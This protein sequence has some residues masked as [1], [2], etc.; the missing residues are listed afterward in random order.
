MKQNKKRYPISLII[1]SM[2]LFS[3]INGWGEFK[4]PASHSSQMSQLKPRLAVQ[5]GHSLQ[6]YHTAFSADGKYLVTSG[7]GRSLRLW[8]VRS[9]REIRDFQM[10]TTLIA[11]LSFVGKS[12]H[13]L[14]AS[15][16]GKLILWDTRT[17]D[18]EILSSNREHV[19]AALA[20]S[21]DGNFA[22][23][24]D[25][26]STLSYWDIRNRRL[27]RHFNVRP[28][29]Q[30]L[31]E[32][33]LLLKPIFNRIAAGLTFS[34]DGGLAIIGM[35][36]DSIRFQDLKNNRGLR[37]VKNVCFPNDYFSLE[38][39]GKQLH[40]VDFN[41][42]RATLPIGENS[43]L[44]HNYKYTAE[45]I[46]SEKPGNN[47][48]RNLFEER[49]R[50]RKDRPK[51]LS[52]FIYS[53]ENELILRFYRSNQ[54]K[55]RTTY[56]MPLSAPPAP[57]EGLT[58]LTFVPDQ[59][60]VLCNKKDGN[61]VLVDILN[62]SIIQRFKR[63]SIPCTSV[64]FNPDASKIT[65]KGKESQILRKLIELTRQDASLQ[66][67]EQNFPRA[68]S[69]YSTWDFSS[70]HQDMFQQ[71][72]DNEEKP[73]SR[74]PLRK[75][76][77]AL[78]Q[79]QYG[80][81]FP[82]FIQ[83]ARNHLDDPQ[84]LEKL[85]QANQLWQKGHSSA[86]WKKIA[87][88]LHQFMTPEAEKIF[89]DVELRFER[90]KAFYSN[91]ANS[92]RG[93]TQLKSAITKDNLTIATADGKK[94]DLIQY[95]KAFPRIL[96]IITPE[97][98]NDENRILQL[99]TQ[100]VPSIITTLEG[101]HFNI[102]MLA[103]SK[104][105][106]V[107]LSIAENGETK[108]W[109]VEKEK[110][111]DS[112]NIP[113]N[114][115]VKKILFSIGEQIILLIQE[116]GTIQGVQKKERKRLFSIKTNYNQV[117]KANS[118]DFS[119]R[120]RMLSFGFPDGMC[121]LFNTRTGREYGS[122]F[123]FIDGTWAIV[124]PDGRF[125]TNNLED[126][127]GLHWVMP[128][129]PM[130]PMS[131]EIFMR[132]YYE[133]KLLPRILAGETLPP[134]PPL[135]QLNRVQPLVEIKDISPQPGNPARVT[136]QVEVKKAT[137][138]Y[139]GQEKTTGVYDLRLFRDRQLVG[140]TPGIGK[141]ITVDPISHSRTLTF[142]NIKLPLLKDK[143]EV[144]FSAYAFNNHR[145]KSQTHRK[146]YPIPQNLKPV[147]GKAYIVTVGVNASENPLLDL[148]F[149]ANDAR[150]MSRTLKK[151]LEETGQYKEVVAVPLISDS[152]TRF[153]SRVITQNNATKANFKAVLDLLA[154]RKVGSHIKSAIPNAH[155]LSEANPEDL[156]FILFSSHGATDEKGNFFLFPSDI[157]KGTNA[158]LKKQ[159][160][161]NALN[162][163]RSAQMYRPKGYRGSRGRRPLAL[164]AEAPPEGRRRHLAKGPNSKNKK[165]Q[166]QLFKRCISSEELSH[167][168][169]D[170]DAGEM[171]MIVDACYSAGA[172][173]TTGFKPGPMGSRGLGQLAY[174]KGMRILAATQADTIALESNRLK[175]GLLTYALVPE[176]IEKGKADFS[177]KDNHISLGE[178]LQ[179]GVKRVPKLYNNIPSS[180]ASKGVDL[181]VPKYRFQQ[182]ALFD[183]TQKKQEVILISDVK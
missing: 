164:A 45:H 68:S 121:K 82:S 59:L 26:D 85:E 142:S 144:Q 175:H 100:F 61:L 140:Y 39:D 148:R 16:D 70:G 106:D 10:D 179:Y 158:S 7:L 124:T 134:I 153:G 42:I 136:V 131:L 31:K 177:P 38:E 99:F 87:E 157:G 46:L 64:Q 172:V 127:K 5:L 137:G 67:I 119:P 162:S 150:I 122:L 163:V 107:L 69:W 171:V 83:K 11:A 135:M 58:P 167:W 72:L 27:I 33:P 62:G 47:S 169:R 44:W 77:D 138:T 15:L 25:F 88:A 156:V 128:D 108:L 50:I 139:G 105:N 37:I 130:K 24:M 29:N 161:N 114:S 34:K 117:I 80:H 154:G 159:T 81:G 109:D 170:V 91:L 52:G 84:D 43:A 145:V 129:D 110:E 36:D 55:F 2:L 12:Y 75:F 48:P 78:Q 160:N 120:K 125:D 180:P 3:A 173:E 53:E 17:G 168:L 118:F 13:V 60:Q 65:I 40:L 54:W 1:F 6:V 23:T 79:I 21:R 66:Q 20:I 102:Q 152:Q 95:K 8:G 141:E 76:Y 94:I 115:P 116:D 73:A 104:K 51:D 28:E 101:H 182:P 126:I 57:N 176:G 32:K 4:P 113:I 147:K 93:T 132:D 86:A 123:S 151:R 96:E 166:A 97:D 149:A 56:G 41:G 165:N 30:P 143:K 98:F 19:F 183:F 90:V 181:V 103:F 174:N 49:Y 14:C 63:Q 18:A 133:P 92:I 89:D 112:W 178:W 74:S 71:G 155:H 111:L 35:L 22:L 9:G 146:S